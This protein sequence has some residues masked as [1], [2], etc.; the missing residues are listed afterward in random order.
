MPDQLTLTDLEALACEVARACG[1][2][3]VDDR[4]DDLGVA[5]TKSSVVDVVTDMDRRSESLARRLLT[6]ARPDDALL[7]LDFDSDTAPTA[8]TRS[9]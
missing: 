7:A 9:P 6:Q 2:L 5:A 1:R 8:K 3:I 4:P